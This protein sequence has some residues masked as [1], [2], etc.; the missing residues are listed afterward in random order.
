MKVAAGITTVD[1]ILKTSPPPGGDRR[2][3]AH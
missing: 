2:Q 1:E 3:L